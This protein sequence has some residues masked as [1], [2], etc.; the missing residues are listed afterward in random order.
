MKKAKQLKIKEEDKTT[1]RFQT[2]ASNFPDLGS[3]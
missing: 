1:A 2:R 3:F